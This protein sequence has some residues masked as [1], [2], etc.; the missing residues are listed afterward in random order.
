MNQ[1]SSL[2]KI[3]I[4]ALLVVVVSLIAPLRQS[5]NGVWQFTTNAAAVNSAE[6]KRDII[7]VPGNWDTLT[8]YWQMRKFFTPVDLLTASSGVLSVTP[9]RADEIPHC[10]LRGCRLKR[11]CGRV[12][13]PDLKPGDPV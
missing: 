3:T 11:D 10:T 6:A 12:A 7:T 5:L 2:L 1:P 8:A 13:L 4:A 9:R